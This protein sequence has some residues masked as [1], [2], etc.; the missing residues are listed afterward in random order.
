M[1]ES[2]QVL[3]AAQKKAA[4]DVLFRYEDAISDGYG[5]YAGVKNVIPT[6]EGLAESVYLAIINSANLEKEDE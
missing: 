4:V 5:F 6:L 2:K 1:S 3:S